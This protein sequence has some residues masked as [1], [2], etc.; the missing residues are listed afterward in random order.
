MAL[1]LEDIFVAVRERH[2]ERSAPE[3][4]FLMPTSKLSDQKDP[5]IEYLKK[6]D[7]FFMVN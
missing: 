6:N 5:E 1:W 3:H 2:L 4:C 7:L